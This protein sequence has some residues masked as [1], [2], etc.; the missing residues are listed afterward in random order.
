MAGKR[1]NT[2]GTPMHISHGED[3]KSN[4]D[5]RHKANCAHYS[6][7]GKCTM[8]S[9]CCGSARCNYYREITENEKEDRRVAKSQKNKYS[10][11]DFSDILKQ[12]SLDVKSE[13]KKRR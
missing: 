9:Y 13:R 2:I 7:N 3:L 10:E 4:D 12:Y 5:R 8:I 1:D 6:G 11:S